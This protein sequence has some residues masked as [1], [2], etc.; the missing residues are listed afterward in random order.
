MSMTAFNIRSFYLQLKTEY[1]LFLCLH[2]ISANQEFDASVVPVCLAGGS[3][4]RVI[5]Q[6]LSSFGRSVNERSFRL[7]ALKLILAD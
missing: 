2:C 5:F 6:W 1:F 4:E 7:I 3:R